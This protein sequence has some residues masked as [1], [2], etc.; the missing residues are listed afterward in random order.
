MP[1]KYNHLPKQI[2]RIMMATY[3]KLYGFVLSRVVHDSTPFYYF[4]EHIGQHIQ[5]GGPSEF[6][7]QILC[8]NSDPTTMVP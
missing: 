8:T 5:M 6:R 4:V 3:S 1:Y 7:L 2:K